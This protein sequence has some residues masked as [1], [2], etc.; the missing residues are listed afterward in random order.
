MVTLIDEIHL[1]RFQLITQNAFLYYRQ[2]KSGPENAISEGTC[3]A[4]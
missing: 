2:R 4:N 1:K 3:P